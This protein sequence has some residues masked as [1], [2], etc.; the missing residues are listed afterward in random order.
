MNGSVQNSHM[1][2]ITVQQANPGSGSDRYRKT[3]MDCDSNG[4]ARCVNTKFR[5][6]F[7]SERSDFAASGMNQS[8]IPSEKFKTHIACNPLAVALTEPRL[9]LLIICLAK[10][11]A[12]KTLG[13]I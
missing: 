6:R 10:S 3:A 5:A 8:I 12:Q 11:F 13:E 1:P 2:V 9:L 4:P 7:S